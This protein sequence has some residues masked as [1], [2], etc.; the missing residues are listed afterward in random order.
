[1]TRKRIF[2]GSASET[3]DELAIPIAD[4]LSELGYDVERWWGEGVF[5][6]GDVTH[7]RLREIAA[8]VEGA[9]FVCKGTDDLWMKSKEIR[10][11]RDNVIFELGMFFQTLSPRACVV[12]KDDDTE[13]P[14]DLKGLTYLPLCG[15][16][17]T[18]AGRVGRH[19]DDL[20]R[21]EDG[22][23]WRS[24]HVIKVEIDPYLA[25]ISTKDVVP[26]EWHARALYF[27]NEGGRRWLAMVTDPDYLKDL[28]KHQMQQQ[29][30]KVVANTPISAVVSF[31]PGDAEVDRALVLELTKDGDELQY[32]PV[33]ISGGL[34]NHSCRIIQGIAHVP[35]GLLTDFEDR[36]NFVK[37]RLQGRLRKRALVSLLG[38]AFGNLDRGE[39]SFMRQVESV[40]RRDDYLLLEVA[41]AT[42]E[43][44]FGGD[45]R[46]DMSGHNKTV[47]YFYSQG[48]A[49]QT[50]EALQTIYN[51]YV[52]RI[53]SQ[54]GSSDV[55]GAR[56][57]EYVD[58]RTKRT[59]ISLRR[60][61]WSEFK[62]WLSKKFNFDIAAESSLP[63]D[64]GEIGI[65]AVLLRKR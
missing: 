15:D 46:F 19:F 62:K 12:V 42:P 57:V 28:Q 45:I 18:I 22:A 44:S 59:V 11:P 56:S 1:M 32:I 34:L 6:N 21:D 36:M 40:L 37:E 14:S 39:T 9:V 27:G 47:R 43:W 8:G 16:A 7:E 31:G 50:G 52:K 24:P 2:I 63:F 60:Y 58:A 26:Q 33:D 3:K 64:E 48:L 23:R 25:D 61:D 5:R 54:Q 38:N 53:I 29:L 49:R 10:V 55:A 20:F 65:G 35:F 13:L 4:R 51:S 17:N 30:L 41:I